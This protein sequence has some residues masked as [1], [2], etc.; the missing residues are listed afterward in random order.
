MGKRH[1]VTLTPELSFYLQYKRL[2]SASIPAETPIDIKNLIKFQR[3][4]QKNPTFKKALDDVAAK[5]LPKQGSILN[6]DADAN[7]IQEEIQRSRRFDEDPIIS[8]TRDAYWF[9]PETGQP[10]NGPTVTPTTSSTNPDIKSVTQWLDLKT[11]G[12]LRQEKFF[13]VRRGWR[14]HRIENRNSS[15]WDRLIGNNFDYYIY[16]VV[17]TTTNGEKLLLREKVDVGII[18]LWWL[19]D[20][21]AWLFDLII[22][23]A[24]VTFMYVKSGTK[25]NITFMYPLFRDILY[26]QVTLDTFVQCLLRFIDLYRDG[27]IGWLAWIIENTV[28]VLQFFFGDDVFDFGEF[29]VGGWYGRQRALGIFDVI[30]LEAIIDPKK[31]VKAIQGKIDGAKKI[32]MGFENAFNIVKNS[33]YKKL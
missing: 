21:I 11:N 13:G 17:G 22:W 29:E 2:G 1:P 10:V 24:I 12:N 26:G 33:R 16:K 6:E 8:T 3:L 15:F 18:W 31:T 19:L 14:V 28:K 20:T 25:L 5:W 9:N 32:Q 7:A 30:P 27:I 23:P 4:S